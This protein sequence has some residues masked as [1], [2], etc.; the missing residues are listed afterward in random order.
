MTLIT[1]EQ[2]KES[3]R[4]TRPNCYKYGKLIQDLTTDPIT[5][6]HI[7]SIAHYFPTVFCFPIHENTIVGHENIIKNE[8]RLRD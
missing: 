5:K 8:I 4:K 7:D 3:L 6:L 1:G 2:Y